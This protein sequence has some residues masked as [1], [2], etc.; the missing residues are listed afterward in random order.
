VD[1]N[2]LVPDVSI[3]VHA[4]L[5]LKYRRDEAEAASVRRRRAIRWKTQK[6]N[7]TS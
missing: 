6:T 1:L 3:A 4:E 7:V 2:S 5:L